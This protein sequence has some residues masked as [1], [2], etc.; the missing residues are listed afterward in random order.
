MAG[1]RRA[2]AVL[3]SDVPAIHV[4]FPQVSG[5]DV[6]A[7]DKHGHDVGSES[8]LTK[9]RRSLVGE[10]FCSARPRESGDPA[11][12]VLDSRLRGNE[13][14]SFVM[15]GLGP[16]IHVLLLPVSKKDVDTRD[17]R[18]HDGSGEIAQP[19]RGVSVMAGLVPAIHVFGLPPA[20][21]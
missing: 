9:I 17:K 7:R 14:V 11:H 10:V 15:A 3:A 13:R 2:S 5:K 21:C 19:G 18:G 12:K 4:L 8:L 20:A 16:A 6:D 1:T